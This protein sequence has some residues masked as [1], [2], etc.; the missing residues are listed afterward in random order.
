MFFNILSVIPCQQNLMSR[1]SIVPIH[2]YL[3]TQCMTEKQSDG[4]KLRAWIW[5]IWSVPLLKDLVVQW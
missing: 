5:R 2:L 4:K 3:P 1:I